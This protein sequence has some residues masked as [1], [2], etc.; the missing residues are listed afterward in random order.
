[1]SSLPPSKTLDQF[2]VRFPDGMRDRIRDEAATNS[3]SMNT[4]IIER[5]AFTFEIEDLLP[6]WEENYGVS[7]V[8]GGFEAIIPLF[9][10]A[11]SRVAEIEACGM[12]SL[13]V[14][15]QLKR[16]MRELDEIKR[17]L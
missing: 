1:M 4:E 7:T 6:E 16:I 12:G 11:A 3:R 2:V 15:D 5:L 9:E 13:D 17:K 14:N 8:G 10:R